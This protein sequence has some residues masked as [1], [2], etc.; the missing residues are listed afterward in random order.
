MGIDC[1]K[2]LNKIDNSIGE[3]VLFKKYSKEELLIG[4]INFYYLDQKYLNDKIEAFRD[5]KIN[6][7]DFRIIIKFIY[8]YA[9]NN[10]VKKELKDVSYYEIK[11]FNEFIHNNYVYVRNFLARCIVKERKIEYDSKQNIYFEPESEVFRDYERI[12]DDESIANEIADQ[13]KRLSKYKTNS[14]IFL[15]LAKDQ[16]LFV[17][18]KS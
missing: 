16:F 11:E 2:L 3:D 17:K 6:I 12:S 13:V 10:E 9:K 7:S 15:R 5:N 8:K 4:L 18:C 14:K 1:E